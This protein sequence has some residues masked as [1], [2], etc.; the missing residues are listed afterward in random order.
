DGG[1]AHEARAAQWRGRRD[2]GLMWT[3]PSYRR[4]AFVLVL[5]LGLPLAGCDSESDDDG[6]PFVG[7]WEVTGVR[8]NDQN[9]T[10]FILAEIEAIEAEFSSDGSF[11]LTVVVD[12][13]A[14]TTRGNYA[15]G[16]G[17]ITFTSEGFETP[18]V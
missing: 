18:V 11:E 12:G 1:C 7:T 10:A 15:L 3:M 5:A 6:D 9:V 8:V 13:A 17:T 2:Q 14:E 16:E 4:L